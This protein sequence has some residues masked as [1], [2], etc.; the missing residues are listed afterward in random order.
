MKRALTFVFLLPVLAAFAQPCSPPLSQIDL[1]GNALR[2]RILNAADF[3]WDLSNAIYHPNYT[4]G[5][6]NPSTIFLGTIWYGGIDAGG[7]IR[8]GAGGYRNASSTTAPFYTG[9]LNPA[10]GTTTAGA[11]ANWDRFFRV[12][13]AQ[14]DAFLDDLSDGTLSA[15]HNAVRGW[16]ARGNPFFT[17]VT[18]FSL[19]D[20][21][22]A[23]F[24]DEDGDGSYDPMKGDY[25]VVQLQ[26]L[27]AFVPDEQIW[28]I[29]NDQG[30]SA[31]TTVVTLPVEMHLT[32]FA[33]NCPDKPLIHNAMFTSHKLI[34]R[35]T[36]ALDSFSLALYVDFDLG[37]YTDDYLGSHPATN[38]FYAYNRTN[39]DLPPGSC[40]GVPSYG[41]NPPAQ[42]VTFL[43]HSLDRFMPIYN[44]SV[45]APLPATT[46]PANIP[47]YFRYL[48][49]SWRDGLPL[50]SGGSGYDPTLSTP[51]A[52]HAFPGN[53]NNAGEWSMLGTNQ[54]GRDQRG[55]GAHQFGAFF[56]GQI[57]ELNAAWTYHR[58]AGL[59]HLQNVALL[60][61]EVP[62]LPVLYANNF[63]DVCT[64]SVSTSAAATRP[65]L[66]M[67]PNPATGEVHLR[68][69]AASSGTVRVFDATGR[70]V[71]ARVFADTDTL[72]LDTGAWPGG[73]Y[74][75]QIS[76]A[77]G[78]A[79]R[80]LVVH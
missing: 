65:E 24:H 39:T 30:G 34:N 50:T 79:V 5:I 59:S 37:C 74:L 69:A 42:A 78:A 43:N 68:L 49:G 33:F 73:T 62:H 57:V 17:S 60:L 53:P 21:P 54:P 40:Q 61:D 18:G 8:M 20:Q 56:P 32:Y 80:K 66:T 71:I 38:T 15:P 11:C 27:D 35:S 9:P 51:V 25:P 13:A 7:N 22:L 48:T 70:L 29:V 36:E 64:S 47:E 1:N 12:T 52:T 16:P 31:S 67:W 6:A 75:V 3:G 72:R 55:L 26:G 28:T 58:G 19:P 45:G 77:S 10:T 76:T 41:L 2:A 63:A 44:A 46:D 4:A 23:P 14:I